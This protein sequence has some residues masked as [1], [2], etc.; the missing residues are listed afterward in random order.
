[1]GALGVTV[2]NSSSGVELTGPQQ[3]SDE[4]EVCLKCH[5]GYPGPLAGRANVA[6]EFDTLNRSMH[7]VE[8]APS[9]SSAAPGSFVQHSP[10]WTNQS[11]MRCTDCH[12]N[13]DGS[14]PSGPHISSAAPILKSP[15]LGVSP[16]DGS[17]FCYRCHQYDVYY[18]GSSD[19]T[20]SQSNFYS[21]SPALPA[22]HSQHMRTY[23]LG[24]EACHASHGSTTQPHLLRDDIGFVEQANG[25]T[26][27]NA[28][29]AAPEAYAR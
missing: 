18:S 20:D 24:C 23:G 2:T 25:G 13:A 19:T 7:G 27:T 3:A 21:S 10:A 12:G 11:V 28:C 17:G 9:G 26:C 1:V 15:Y 14:A 6:L 16:S 8:A 22:L 29:H 5:S 4:Y